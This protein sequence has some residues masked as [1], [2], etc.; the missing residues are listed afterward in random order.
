MISM[1]IPEKMM[2]RNRVRG[3]MI[4]R[5][6]PPEAEYRAATHPGRRWLQPVAKRWPAVVQ[7]HI[8]L[9]SSIF[10]PMIKETT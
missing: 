1:L 5:G 2:G 6:A 10:T 7:G 8:M 9:E 3:G 4:Q